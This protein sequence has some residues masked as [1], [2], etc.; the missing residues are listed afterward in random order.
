VLGA[1]GPG[2]LEQFNGMLRRMVQVIDR[3]G[4]LNTPG[5]AETKTTSGAPR[6]RFTQQ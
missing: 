6:S 4:L 3:P 2:E 5:S 1:L